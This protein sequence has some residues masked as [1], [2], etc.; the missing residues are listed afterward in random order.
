MLTQ[1][2]ARF[3]LKAVSSHRLDGFIQL[4]LP[5]SGVRAKAIGPQCC[6]VS[7]LTEIDRAYSKALHTGVC[8]CVYR[9]VGCVCV[10]VDSGGDYKP[11]RD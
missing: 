2:I 11:E 9:G 7:L 8:V 10:C 1:S 6:S 4:Q 3:R 5:A